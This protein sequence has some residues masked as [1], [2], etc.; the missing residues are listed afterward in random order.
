MVSKQKFVGILLLVLFCACKKHYEY[1]AEGYVYKKGTTTP[2]SDVPIIMA[3]CNHTG[4]RCQYSTIATTKTDVN[5]YYRILGNNN[6]G[7]VSI[8]VA[9]NE[10]TFGSNEVN[11]FRYKE[12]FYHNFYVDVAQ[13]LT[14]RFIIQTQNRNFVRPTVSVLPYGN[15]GA[16]FRNPAALIDTTISAR[17]VSGSEVLLTVFLRN[18]NPTAPVYSDTLFYQRNLGVLEKDTSLVWIV[19]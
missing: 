18:E 16:I 3:E 14:A 7:S 12:I 1:R 19:P 8:E 13:K 9:H 10:K 11:G 17:F 6:S 2:I 5:G 4:T 15:A